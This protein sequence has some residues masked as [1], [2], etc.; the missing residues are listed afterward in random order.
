MEDTFE[1]DQEDAVVD[2]RPRR[3]GASTTALRAA[4]DRP[5]GRGPAHWAGPRP[6]RDPEPAKPVDVIGGAPLGRLPPTR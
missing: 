4:L 6:E 2:A 5:A 1:H 3:R